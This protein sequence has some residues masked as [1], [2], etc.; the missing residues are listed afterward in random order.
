MTKADSKKQCNNQP[1]MGEANACDGGGGNGDS[2][3]SGRCGGGQ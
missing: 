1:T 3:G 2:N